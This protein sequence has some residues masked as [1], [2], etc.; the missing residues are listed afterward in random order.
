MPDVATTALPV[1]RIEHVFLCIV[2]G[3]AVLTS[4]PQNSHLSGG[5]SGSFCGSGCACSWWSSSCS[6]SCAS[7]RSLHAAMCFEMA[8]RLPHSLPQYVQVNPPP[9][10]SSSSSS[11]SA[12]SASSAASSSAS[13]ASSAFSTF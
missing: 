8:P 12:S 10:P 5:K 9:P 3:P 11:A 1:G 13:S 7:G 2:S 6:A 4:L